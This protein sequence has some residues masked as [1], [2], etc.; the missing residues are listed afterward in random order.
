MPT[1]PCSSSFKQWRLE[2]VPIIPEIW[3]LMPKASTPKQLTVLR[4]LVKD[5]DQLVH[6]G[7]PDREGQLLV[8][9]QNLSAKLVLA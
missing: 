1:T 6:A 7:D 3:Q 9:H 5:A 2:H 4:N 8:D